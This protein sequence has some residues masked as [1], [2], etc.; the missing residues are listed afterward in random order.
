MGIDHLVY[1]VRPFIPGPIRDFN[2]RR[3]LAARRRYFETF[4]I[5]SV[6]KTASTIASL[7]AAQCRDE[8]FL[9]KEF[10]PSIGL[11][12]EVLHEQPPEFSASYGKGLHIWQYPNQL[13]AYLAWLAQNCSGI[14]SFLEIGCRWGGMFIL[15]SEWIRRNGAD[16]RSVTAV[17]PISP[18]PFIAAYFA[19]LR[20]TTKIDPNYLREFSTSPIV[21]KEIGRL[22]P[23]F[24]FIDGDHTLRGALSDHLL[25]RDHARIIAHH[26]INSQAC[27][28]TT[29]LWQ[30]LKA[31][32]KERFEF[33]E[34]VGQYPSVGR[35]LLGIGA[36]KRKA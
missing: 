6:E 27:P 23:D 25:V 17:D 1:R 28:D 20:A 10:I 30:A 19:Q 13:A 2:S 9:E 7:S 24:V 32:E 18:T 31:L 11:N 26:D 21:K 35:T 5:A 12:D 3:N 29:F 16:L 15:V 4:A 36:M 33:A 14:T 8:A 34:F 22:R